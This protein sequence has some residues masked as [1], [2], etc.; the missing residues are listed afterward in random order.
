MGDRIFTRCPACH[1][2]TLVIN[3][4][5]LLCTWIKC[6]SP[7]VANDIL[8]RVE[9]GESVEFPIA[10]VGKLVAETESN[11]YGGAADG[12]RLAWVECQLLAKSPVGPLFD[13]SADPTETAARIQAGADKAMREMDKPRMM[14]CP[15]KNCFISHCHHQGKHLEDFGC[16]KST[17]CP[18]CVPA[19]EAPCSTAL[20]DGGR[21]GP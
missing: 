3:K 20:R 13:N 11:P 15:D 9:A 16:V 19:A 17:E 6:P 18:A 10:L 5:H 2:D 7:T 8:R 21:V 4:G 14:V 12:V 1:N